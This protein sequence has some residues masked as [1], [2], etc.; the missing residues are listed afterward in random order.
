MNRRAMK[1]RVKEIFGGYLLEEGNS[2][3]YAYTETVRALGR[4]IFSEIMP[5]TLGDEERKLAEMA[6]N[7]QLFFVWVGNKFPYDGIVLGKSYAEKLMKICE[8]CSVLM[9]FLAEHQDKIIT[10][11]IRSGLTK[12]RCLQIKENV[13][14]LSGGLEIA[15]EGLEPGHGVGVAPQTV[16][17]LYNVGGIFLKALFGDEQSDSFQKEFN[18]YIKI[19][20]EVSNSCEQSFISSGDTNNLKP[21]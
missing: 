19:L 1:E 7:V 20:N 18:A 15:I 12:E 11:S 16:R 8:D 17:N 2:M 21:N 3:G 14:K 10:D 13:Q 5:L 4:Q 6:F 9:E